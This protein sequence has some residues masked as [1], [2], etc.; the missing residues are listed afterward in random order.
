MKKI[1]N[2]R[3]L[4]ESIIVS[5]L[6]FG[7]FIGMKVIQGVINTYKYVPD[8]I[9]SYTSANYS[10]HKVSFGIVSVNEF[11]GITL[12]LGVIILILLIIFYY[13]IRIMLNR[14]IKK[15]N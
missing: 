5:I 1:L 14:W 9:D 2:L 13:G 6:I 12:V 4:I 11:N 10:Q 7:L 3:L 15:D 8:V